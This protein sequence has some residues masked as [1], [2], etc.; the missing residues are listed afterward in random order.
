MRE[1]LEKMQK[2]IVG[3]RVKQRVGITRFS[4]ASY[5]TRYFLRGARD[6]AATSRLHT[7]FN[8]AFSSSPIFLPRR[9]SQ[10]DLPH[11]P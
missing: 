3:I 2:R 9:S 8:L 6:H 5:D 1:K 4:T 10:C 7:L 11:I